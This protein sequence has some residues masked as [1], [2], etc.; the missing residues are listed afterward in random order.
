MAASSGETSGKT[1]GTPP[2]IASWL[3]VQHTGVG[4]P[5][6]YHFATTPTTSFGHVK[7]ADARF[8]PS[9]HHAEHPNGSPLLGKPPFTCGHGNWILCFPP[10]TLRFPTSPGLLVSLPHDEQ[11]RNNQ[12]FHRSK[13]FLT[14][15]ILIEGFCTKGIFTE[16]FLTE[17]I[18]TEGFF[19]KS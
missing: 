17:G 11:T 12:T 4:R 5:C 16:D 3:R 9:R 1:T 14:E 2:N 6:H 15:G 10:I 8:P 13:D 7:D 18:L 19:I